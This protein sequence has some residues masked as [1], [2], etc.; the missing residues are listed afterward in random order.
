MGYN[1]DC[2][3]C[4]YYKDSFHQTGHNEWRCDHAGEYF[5]DCYGSICN[6][7]FDRAEFERKKR[8]NEQKTQDL[9]DLYHGTE[10]IDTIKNLQEFNEQHRGEKS[11]SFGCITWIIIIC[12]FFGI[13]GILDSILPPPISYIPFAFAL[14]GLYKMHKVFFGSGE[15]NTILVILGAM[16]AFGLMVDILMKK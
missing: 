9:N 1:G 10:M 15:T 12:V 14:Y 13:A 16:M 5:S 7:Y 6:S 3:D 4:L 11:D 2:R 8:E